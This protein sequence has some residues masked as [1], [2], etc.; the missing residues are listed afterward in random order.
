MSEIALRHG[1]T[2]FLGNFTAS[3]TIANKE[4]VY[5]WNVGIG[6]E[7]DEEGDLKIVDNTESS[8]G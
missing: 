5:K 8:W 3:A 7:G 6:F 1:S 2:L 4:G